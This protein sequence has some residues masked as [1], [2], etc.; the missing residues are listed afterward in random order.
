[1]PLSSLY[2]PSHL[3]ILEGLTGDGFGDEAFVMVRVVCTVQRV[4]VQQTVSPV[5][6]KLGRAHVQKRHRDHTT[7][8]RLLE[9]HVAQHAPQRVPASIRRAFPQH[10]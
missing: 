5:V 1:M 4:V 7:P 6:D 8:P 2:L 9:R 10:P 3:V